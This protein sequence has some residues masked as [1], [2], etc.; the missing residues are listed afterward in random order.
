MSN[1]G[2]LQVHVRNLETL[3]MTLFNK[4]N[5][6]LGT[7]EPEGKTP[8]TLAEVPPQEVGTM[9]I[10]PINVAMEND[11]SQATRRM[12]LLTIGFQS[13]EVTEL[14]GIHAIGPF[15]P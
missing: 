2:K 7:Y 1:T 8:L 14:F 15:K 4:R 9:L 6:V 10:V 11:L 13:P 5:E 12:D 3:E